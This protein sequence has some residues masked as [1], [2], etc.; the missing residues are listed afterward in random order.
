MIIHPG[1]AHE[2]V[3]YE[4]FL[5]KMK[6]RSASTVQSL[7]PQQVTLTTADFTLVMEMEKEIKALGFQFDTFG[8]NTIVVTGMPAEAAG[9]SEKE[10]FE[11]LLEQFKQNQAALSVPL[12]DN[13]ARSLA[14]RASIKIGQAL[15]QEEMDSI[16]D[17]LFSSHNPNYSPDGNT[18]FFIFETSKVE[19]HFR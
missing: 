13:L 8:K 16:V 18:T 15:T 14:R 12:E 1:A 6:D 2:R 11:G 4:S 10:L 5:R 17:R 9:K 7:F 19:S 3:L